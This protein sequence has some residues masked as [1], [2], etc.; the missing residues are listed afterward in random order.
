MKDP[1]KPLKIEKKPL[2]P[3][4]DPWARQPGEL[5]KAWRAFRTFRDAPTPG[6]RELPTLSRTLKTSLTQV[7]TWVSRWSW[8]FRVEAYD[9]HMD[10]A[11]VSAA[12]AE[13]SEMGK[14]QAAAA[15]VAQ[16]ILQAPMKEA[17][18]RIQAGTM[19]LD[20]LSSRDLLQIIRTSAMPF[21]HFAA[22]EQAARGGTSPDEKPEGPVKEIRI[23]V[24]SEP[25][26]LAPT[27]F[28]GPKL[29]QGVK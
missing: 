22:I 10:A 7:E 27:V 26:K 5:E 3:S 17:L 28:E 19:S 12:S 18:R 24:V 21:R 6:G 4:L 25:P 1:E 15:A 8:R 13:H 23:T 29:V 20:D 11:K 9:R 14:R 16:N 2:D